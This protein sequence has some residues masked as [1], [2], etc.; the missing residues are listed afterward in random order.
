MEKPKEEY[1]HIVEIATSALVK[2]FGL[3]VEEMFKEP[4]IISME[5]E[6]PCA[7][8]PPHVK[9]AILQSAATHLL[10]QTMAKLA[11]VSKV[12]QEQV[13]SMSKLV[14]KHQ[15][16][17]YLQAF[18]AVAKNGK[19][20]MGKGPE[21]GND[22]PGLILDPGTQ[23]SDDVAKH[24]VLKHNDCGQDGESRNQVLG[25]VSGEVPA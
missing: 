25:H 8:L 9:S 13:L 6:N 10:A 4:L 20:N 18:E 22:G 5:P 2:A 3:C 1:K 7:G 19:N 23:R 14:L 24:T 12:P 11:F 17:Q 16:Q 21:A 15:F